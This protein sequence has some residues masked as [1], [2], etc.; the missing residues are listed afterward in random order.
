MSLDAIILA[1]SGGLGGGIERYV[2]TLQWA[3]A[4]QGVTCSRFNLV[5]SGA[6]AQIRLAAQAL[7]A[8]RKINNPTRIVL[9]HPNLL[10]IGGF[11]A[12]Q[13]N[14]CGVS[15]ICHG[16][17]AWG[18]KSWPRR[19][20]QKHVMRRPFMRVVAA[21]G[22]TGGAIC[23]SSASTVLPPGLS[24]PWFDTLVAAQR[25]TPQASEI[26]V[27]TAFR[28]G[29]WRAKGFPQLLQAME[30]LDRPSI[31]L[32]VCGSG[33]PPPDLMEKAARYPNCT[34]RSALSDDD[35]AMQLASAHIF[36]LATRTRVGRSPSGEGFGLALLEAQVAGTP[37]VAPA[38]GGSHDAYLD[39]VTGLA[40]QDE[41]SEALAIT[42]RNLLI[43]PEQLAEM[44]RQAAHWAQEVFA[45]ERYAQLAVR[46]L[47]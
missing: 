20:V 46:R 23:T 28:L 7:D 41:S 33:H 40:P 38:F 1:P 32:V 43:R 6:V 25:A 34:V 36:V 16:T 18:S 47:L 8:V 27:V 44:S 30:M 4:S 42:L 9:A 10:P 35:L 37:V 26:Q 22:F 29:D 39:G 5:G 45:P 17:D 12:R 21:S 13:R 19:R 14:I 2:E 11:L 3:F 24:A 31:K 15:V